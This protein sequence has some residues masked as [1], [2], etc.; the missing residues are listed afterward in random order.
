MGSLTQRGLGARRLRPS[1]RSRNAGSVGT[2]L[3]G[4]TSGIALLCFADFKK[5][6]DKRLA[7]IEGAERRATRNRRISVWSA[8]ALATGTGS[9]REVTLVVKLDLSAAN[10]GRYYL[11]TRREEQGQETAAYYYP[12][13][14]G[15]S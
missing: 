9:G 12:V 4:A 15:G 6:R 14:I 10:P 3:H 13:L 7:E 8:A 11:A 5:I 2:I 1:R